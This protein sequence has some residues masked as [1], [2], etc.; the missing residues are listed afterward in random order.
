MTECTDCEKPATHREKDADPSRPYCGRHAAKW[1]RQGVDMVQIY[2][3][4]QAPPWE[5]HEPS[6]G[7]GTGARGLEE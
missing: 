7:M 1:K 4:T 2:I 5:G 3:R 6:T